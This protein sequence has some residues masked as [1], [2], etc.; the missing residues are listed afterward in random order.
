MNREFLRKIANS[1]ENTSITEGATVKGRR[2]D[3][4]A[5]NSNGIY[6]CLEQ[7]GIDPDDI[8]WYEALRE[9]YSLLHGHIFLYTMSGDDELIGCFYAGGGLEAVEVVEDIYDTFETSY[10]FSN[11][12]VSGVDYKPENMRQVIRMIKKGKASD[13][14]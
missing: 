8:E 12:I 3:F 5:I 14:Q 7:K 9:Q 2:V 13:L 1:V 11:L 10:E 4:M 6:I